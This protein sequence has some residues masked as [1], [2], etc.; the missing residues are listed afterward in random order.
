MG[1]L[2]KTFPKHSLEAFE[3]KL[4]LLVS[5]QVPDDKFR[6]SVSLR[7]Q[8]SLQRDLGDLD[9]AQVRRIILGLGIF[10]LTEPSYNWVLGGERP[11]WFDSTCHPPITESDRMVMEIYKSLVGGTLLKKHALD[12][13]SYAWFCKCLKTSLKATCQPDS[14]SGV[15]K[16]VERFREKGALLLYGMNEIESLLASVGRYLADAR[17]QSYQRIP[18]L[19]AATFPEWA[20]HYG[21]TEDKEMPSLLLEEGA[22]FSSWFAFNFEVDSVYSVGPVLGLSVNTSPWKA[23]IYW[24]THQGLRPLPA[25][26]LSLI[27]MRGNSTA[28]PGWAL[29][30]DGGRSNRAINHWMQRLYW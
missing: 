20:K 17:N 3:F 8:S 23:I 1:S 22:D 10:G 25:R 21:G 2:L 19:S 14:D 4:D 26:V 28:V 12:L 9:E 7:V 6:P 24:K 16:R 13:A 30:M 27:E 5:G 18:K 15:I 29:Q 11:P